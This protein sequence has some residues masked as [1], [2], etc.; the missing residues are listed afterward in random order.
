MSN[1]SVTLADKKYIRETT[2]ENDKVLPNN[3]W[4]FVTKFGW[5]K[6]KEIT[7]EDGTTSLALFDMHGRRC[8]QKINGNLSTEESSRMNSFIKGYEKFKLLPEDIRSRI[9]SK[10]F[11]TKADS[12]WGRE[13]LAAEKLAKTQLTASISAKNE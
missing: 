13:T 7:E 5:V 2:Y 10:Y 11:F 12:K 1:L 6:L 4:D 9:I 3:W 8:I